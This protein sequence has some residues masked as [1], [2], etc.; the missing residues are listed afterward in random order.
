MSDMMAGKPGVQR[1][2]VVQHAPAV[3]HERWPDQSATFGGKCRWGAVPDLGDLGRCEKRPHTT[4]VA[5]AYGA[6]K[7]LNVMALSD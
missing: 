5:S 2:F 7:H 3:T 6:N 4:I 1:F